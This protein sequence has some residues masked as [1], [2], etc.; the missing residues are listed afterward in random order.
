M[1][2]SIALNPVITVP[3][4]T[5]LPA[6]PWRDP[7][8]VSPEELSG[9]IAVLKKACLDNP[10]S[11]DLRVALG[12]AYAMD[13]NVYDSMDALELATQLEPE[14]FWAQMKYAELQYRMRTLVVAEAETLKAVDLAGNP[15]ELS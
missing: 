7:H 4:V 8:A 3:G 13:Y 11:A 2:S 12:M 15:W 6:L 1:S 14:H 10:K 5:R 9:Y